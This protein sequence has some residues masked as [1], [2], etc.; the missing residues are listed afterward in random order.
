MFDYK[1]PPHPG[2]QHYFDEL[3]RCYYVQDGTGTT[4]WEHPFEPSF[5]AT[6]PT[7]M[8]P[9]PAV[10]PSE[11]HSKTNLLSGVADSSGT[12]RQVRNNNRPIQIV[13]GKGA[14]NK[15]TQ[16][17]LQLTDF[18]TVNVNHPSSSS[19]PPSSSKSD[20]DV[21]LPFGWYEFFDEN[22]NKY[23]HDSRTGKTQW[24]HPT[25]GQINTNAAAS[26][27]LPDTM[28]TY[29]NLQTAP[30]IPP[31][32]YQHEYDQVKME[33][34]AAKYLQFDLENRLQSVPRMKITKES[35][36][37]KLL[38]SCVNI[39][40][41]LGIALIIGTVYWVSIIT[42][43]V[44]L[45][46]KGDGLMAIILGASFWACGISMALGIWCSSSLCSSSPPIVES[47][48]GRAF[49]AA[50]CW[51]ADFV[52]FDSI[53]NQIDDFEMAPPQ[54][55]INIHCYRIDY[56]YN[57]TTNTYSSSTKTKCLT[58]IP[59]NVQGWVDKSGKGFPEL[60]ETDSPITSVKWVETFELFPEQRGLL[61]LYKQELYYSHLNCSVYCDVNVGYTVLGKSNTD[62]TQTSP[63]N[64]SSPGFVLQRIC[65]FNPLAL[66]FW[67]FLFGCG[68]VPI[69]LHRMMYKP[70]T[71]HSV[72]TLYLSDSSKQ[73]KEEIERITAAK[74]RRYD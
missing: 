4:T 43:I 27:E 24:E 17:Y 31:A 45:L 40:C 53:Q 50:C 48:S 20:K 8:T 41:S 25:T 7:Q 9:Q 13:R 33:M 59:I 3:G 46:D 44:G 5:V 30:Y 57:A 61:D 28:T 70:A 69:V 35:I 37:Y 15:P 66:L 67:V 58:S 21:P 36:R 1:M 26:A 60:L 64:F 52:P 6:K 19:P 56:Y 18:T 49:R 55:S 16:D 68:W 34:E 73:V 63:N 71:Y 29:A 11:D 54:L 14:V 65:C 39:A 12:P 38:D 32:D 10:Y 74:Y 2:W 42:L 51:G 23:Y 72:K 22:Q 47:V 62:V